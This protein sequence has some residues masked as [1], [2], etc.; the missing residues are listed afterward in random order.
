M[1]QFGRDV[2]VDSVKGKEFLHKSVQLF[3]ETRKKESKV[4]EGSHREI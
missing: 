2:V 1:L 4:L 3:F